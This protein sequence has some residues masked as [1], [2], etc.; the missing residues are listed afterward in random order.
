MDIQIYAIGDFWKKYAD[1]YNNKE[2]YNINIIL[3]WLTYGTL[4]VLYIF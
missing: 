3:T 2:S 4:I 1:K